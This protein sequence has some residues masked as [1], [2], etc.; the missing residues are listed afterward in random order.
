MTSLDAL[1]RLAALAAEHSPGDHAMA[2][3]ID[4][5][6][7]ALEASD[8]AL[9]YSAGD[10]GFR[11][12][13]RSVAPDLSATA[14]WSVHHELAT[15]DRPVGI[16]MAGSR[17]GRFTD[18]GEHARVDFIA[19]TIPSRHDPA[20]MLVA[21]GPWNEGMTAERAAFVRAVAPAL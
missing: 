6:V 20:Q 21:R 1:E 18:A 9:T 2:L 8:V 19:A 5:L 12:F 11:H 14:L 4:M 15:R 7:E 16:V 3:A 17:T 13:G 10:G